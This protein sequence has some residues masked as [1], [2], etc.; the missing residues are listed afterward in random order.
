MTLTSL[1][2]DVMTSDGKFMH[3][4]VAPAMNEQ[5]NKLYP[6][7]SQDQNISTSA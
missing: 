6:S 1:S 2:K 4:H 7:I 5:L 3:A